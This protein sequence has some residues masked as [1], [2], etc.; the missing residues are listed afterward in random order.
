MSTIAAIAR[1]SVLTGALLLP[2]GAEEP[3]KEAAAPAPAQ[4]EPPQVEKVGDT[5]FKI[6]LIEFD[7]ATREIRFPARVNM[8]E[9]MIEFPITHENGRVHE[10]IFITKALPLHLET[11]LRLL[12]FKASPEVFPT[13]PG[14]DFN[15][16]PP[17]EEWPDPVYPA[18]IPESHVQVFVSWADKKEPVDIRAMLYRSGE[19][20]TEDKDAVRFEKLAPHWVFTGSNEK[21]GL[22]VESLGGAIVG[23]RPEPACSINTVSSEIVHQLEWFADQKRI[24]APDT[25]V[26]IHIRPFAKPPTSEETKP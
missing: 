4:P 9:G 18:A 26:T 2:L 10:A 20:S 15:N 22:E 7:S 6:G 11:A 13:Y 24:P 25:Q 14:V 5:G 23:I 19:E 16:P 21:M 3:S 17:Y 12:R 8:Q 1:L